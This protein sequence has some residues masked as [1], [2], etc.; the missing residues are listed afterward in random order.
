MS[1]SKLNR[2][3]ALFRK[4]QIVWIEL[5]RQVYFIYPKAKLNAKMKLEHPSMKMKTNNIVQRRKNW[6]FKEIDGVVLQTLCSSVFRLKL[7]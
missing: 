7:N 3:V 4:H 1:A 2:R 6:P 5:I